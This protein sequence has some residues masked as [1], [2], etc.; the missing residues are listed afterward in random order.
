M[1]VIIILI[2]VTAVVIIIVNNIVSTRSK[3]APNESSEQFIKRIFG[4]KKNAGG[5]NEGIKDFKDNQTV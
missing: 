2:V 5:V 4:K 1:K 3:K